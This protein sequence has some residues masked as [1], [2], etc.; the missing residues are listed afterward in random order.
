MAG[1]SSYAAIHSRVRV[2]YAGLIT[3]QLAVNLRD[4]PDL[5]AL[6]GV[7]RGTPYGSYLK[8]L[9]D[10]DLTPKA[11]VY[12]FRLRLGDV[13]STIIHSAPTSTRPLIIQLFRRYEIDNLKT[14]LRGIILGSSWEDIRD[15]LFPMGALNSLPLRAM[16]EAG[17][18]ETAVSRASQTPYYETLVNALKRFGEEQSLFPLEVALDLSYWRKLWAITNQLPSSDHTAA[19]RVVGPLVDLTNLMWAIRYRVYYRL[20]EEEVINYT[21]PFGHRVRDED[22]RAIA[23]GA[24]ISG[25]VNRIFPGLDDLDALLADP[26]HGLPKLELQLQRRLRR[27]FHAVFT[28]YPFQIGLPLALVELNELEIQD[29][30]VMVEA[31]SSGMSSAVFS[32]YLLMD[33]GIEKVP[34]VHTI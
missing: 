24:D 14:L 6:L 20:S 17:N 12:R 1:P 28:G 32:P 5:S 2:M 30:T 3:P 19:L 4:A 22:I 31:I 7:L 34:L 29:L 13:Y 18:V 9:D 10:K 25:V 26:E 16:L 23:A 27:Q 8:T 11:L 33:L 21:L 15:I